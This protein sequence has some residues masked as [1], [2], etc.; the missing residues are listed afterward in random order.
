M[1]RSDG[2]FK[3]GQSGNP[4]G[5]PKDKHGFKALAR[6]H[7]PEALERLLSIMR[8]NSKGHMPSVVR[9]CEL[10][11]AHGWGKP[12]AELALTDGEEKRDDK[13][14]PMAVQEALYGKDMAINGLFAS[15]RKRS[16]LPPKTDIPIPKSML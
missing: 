7:A 16:A 1:A 5:C 12:P 6:E 11:I 13:A 8:N 3:K 2:Y 15:L 9:S 14:A 10:I 4:G